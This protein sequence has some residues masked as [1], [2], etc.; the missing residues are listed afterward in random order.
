[1]QTA[2]T[3]ELPTSQKEGEGGGK[4]RSESEGDN[5]RATEERYGYL[6]RG[7]ETENGG[8]LARR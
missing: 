3:S 2:T 8:V 4:R 7:R 5:D 6:G 1:M